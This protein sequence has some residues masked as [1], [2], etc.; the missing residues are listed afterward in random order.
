MWIDN[1]W[2]GRAFSW[3]KIPWV[4]AKWKELSGGKPFCIKG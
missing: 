1:V 3:E 2:H 4:M